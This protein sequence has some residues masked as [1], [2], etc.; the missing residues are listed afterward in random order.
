MKYKN[1]DIILIAQKTNG[2]CFYCGS[3]E[4]CEI[5][6]FFPTKLHKEWGN[7]KYV[8]NDDSKNLFLACQNCNRRK[9][10]KH[11]EEFI[12]S[13]FTAWN[14]FYRANYRVGLSEY[15]NYSEVL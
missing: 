6:H 1:S 2:H 5:D 4:K 13:E 12:G 7:E 10:D 8:N 15:K 9:K 11:P 14:R 3:K